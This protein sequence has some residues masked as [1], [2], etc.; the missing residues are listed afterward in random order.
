M[1][2]QAQGSLVEARLLQI[3]EVGLDGVSLTMKCPSWAYVL[4]SWS[5]LLTLF[6]RF[7]KL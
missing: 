2:V 4:N 5:L 6:G 1:P 7:L 3:Q